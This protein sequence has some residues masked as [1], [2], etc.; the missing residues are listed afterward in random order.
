MT[1]PDRGT[2]HHIR[3]CIDGAVHTWAPVGD[4]CLNPERDNRDREIRDAA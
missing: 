4:V 3:P 1:V 2:R